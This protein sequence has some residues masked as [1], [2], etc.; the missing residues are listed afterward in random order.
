MTESEGK[1]RRAGRAVMQRLLRNEL[2]GLLI[3]L[4]IIILAFSI[5]SPYFLT[6]ENWLN[7]GIQT[8][9]FFILS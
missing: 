1:S 7:I 2:F 8:S 3:A 9:I 4:L 5:L 6:L